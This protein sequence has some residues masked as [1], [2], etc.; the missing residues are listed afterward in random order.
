MGVIT[1]TE[2]CPSCRS[3]GRDSAGDNLCFYDD[4]DGWGICHACDY[5]Q[6]PPKNG[7]PPPMTTP[8]PPPTQRGPQIDKKW[9]DEHGVVDAIT[10]RGYS[11][12]ASEFY[13]ARVIY[14]GEEEYAYAYPAAIDSEVVRYQ[15]RKLP[16]QFMFSSGKKHTGLFG[17]HVINGGGKFVIIVEG[18]DDTLASFDLLQQQKK[19]Y[20]VVGSWGTSGW[21]MGLEFLESF[22]KVVIAFDQDDAGQEAAKELANA[23]T[24]GKGHIAT[25]KNAKDPTDLLHQNRSADFLNAISGAKAVEMGGIITGEAAWNIIKDYRKPEYVP[26]PAEWRELSSNM[27]GLRRAEIS[28]WTAGS[29]IGKTSFMRRIKQ[30]IL[31]ESDWTVADVELEE[32]PVKTVRGL[33]QY[34]AAKRM[35]DMTEEEKRAAWERTYG[36]GRIK[37]LDHRAKRGGTDLIGK[38]RYLH[39]SEGADIIF[40]D[41]VTLGVREFGEGNEGVDAMMEDFLCF[42][43]QTGVHLALI[44]HLRKSPGGGKSWS[45]GAVPAEEDMKGSGSL[46]QIAF[47]IIGMARNKQHED[48]YIRNVT[49]LHSLK[50]RETGK[51][52]PMDHLYYNAE[53]GLIEPADELY[54]ANANGED[55]VAPSQDF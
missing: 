6:P 25:W 16:K 30:N 52:G 26:Y 5:R 33:L 45:Q 22:D 41:H 53:T 38:F 47:D 37:T 17:S 43:E 44:S 23:L 19:N 9:I 11:R 29:S 18:P 27:E 31:R 24:P 39:Y 55:D 34:E 8:A 7:G 51:T 15:V 20:R 46:Y 21:K 48:E 14:K 35:A 12:K 13:G 28:V 4:G 42:V 40:L 2:P 32:Q 50:C 49:Q 10:G 36:T 3:E 1:H 54:L